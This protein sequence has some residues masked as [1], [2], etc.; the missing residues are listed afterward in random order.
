M[1]PA[2]N[3]Y[4][5]TYFPLGPNSLYTVKFTRFSASKLSTSFSP[6]YRMYL[7]MTVRTTYKIK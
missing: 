3:T 2:S 5:N 1:S 4:T 7:N 6:W